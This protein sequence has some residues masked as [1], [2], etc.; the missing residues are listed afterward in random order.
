M[1]YINWNCDIYQLP[2]FSNSD[3]D[4]LKLTTPQVFL[5]DNENEIDENPLCVFPTTT[6]G[7]C[8]LSCVFATQEQVAFKTCWGCVN[9]KGLT[10]F[11]GPVLASV[12]HALAFGQ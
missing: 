1:T 3:R 5:F 12:F 7:S 11:M 4:G 10:N 8:D 2:V 9:L 6:T